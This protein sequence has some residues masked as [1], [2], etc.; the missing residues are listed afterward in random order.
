VQIAEVVHE[1]PGRGVQNF[2]D[3]RRVSGV[4]WMLAEGVHIAEVVYEGPGRGV[5]NF[6][7]ARR[8]SGVGWMLAE[9][10]HIAE[11]VRSTRRRLVGTH[12][13]KADQRT[14]AG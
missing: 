6:S 3:A 5:Q 8:V 4:G 2:S 9:D 11:V 14:L 13:A 12:A 1:G 10:V 7:D